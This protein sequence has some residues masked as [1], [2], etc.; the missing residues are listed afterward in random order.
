MKNTVVA[1]SMFL[2][3][4][5]ALAV[6][7]F[8]MKI[9]NAE[10]GGPEYFNSEDYSEGIFVVEGYFNN[11]PYCHN[12]AENVDALAEDFMENENV[13]VLDV[14]YDCS[15]RDYS[16]WISRHNPNHP[17]LNDCGGTNLLNPLGISSYPTVKVLDCHLDVRFSHTGTWD[18]SVRQ[19]IR[20]V[21]DNL[22][23]EGCAK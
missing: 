15:T 5:V 20:Q 9:M 17:V 23:E 12:N 8:N 3:A 1:I 22:I 11:C 19:E 2:L 13:F 4:S 16:S 7:P 6:G 10:A 18:S 14:G 21:I